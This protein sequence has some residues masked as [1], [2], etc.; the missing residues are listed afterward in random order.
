[1]ADVDARNVK[2]QSNHEIMLEALPKYKLDDLSLPAG[3]E[4]FQDG[5][6]RV[7]GT[8]MYS[9]ITYSGFD[10]LREPGMR[11]L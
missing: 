2:Y 4:R 9:D 10:V 8:G 6:K 5:D 11:I 3:C 1:M 7:K